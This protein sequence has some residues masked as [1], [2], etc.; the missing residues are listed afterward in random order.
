ML[1]SAWGNALDNNDITVLVVDDESFIC[2]AVQAH[3]ELAGFRVLAT[4][5]AR[6]ALDI[7]HTQTVHI[8]FIDINMP[9]MDGLQLLEHIK[10]RRG[11]VL[12]IMM[13]AY[14]SVKK[15]L[16]SRLHGAHDFVI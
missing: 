14:T 4:P 12:V 13:T 16:L 7:V 3:L 2:Q 5:C 15:V 9:N 1:Y 6:Q 11:D 8:A 10:H